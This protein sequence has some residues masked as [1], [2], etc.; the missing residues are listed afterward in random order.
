MQRRRLRI[1]DLSSPSSGFF[2]VSAFLFFA[3][4]LLSGFLLSGCL[5]LPEDDVLQMVSGRDVTLMRFLQV[6]W[7]HFRWI[8]FA[9][10]LSVTTLGLFLLYP[11]VVLRGLLLG[12]SFTALF[13]PGCR[14]AVLLR[15]FLTALLTCSPLLLLAACGV[16]RAARELGRC[17]GG[18]GLFSRPLFLLLLSFL[19][20]LLC[21][22]AELWLL[23]GFASH[24]QPFT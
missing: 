19:L 13:V 11:L 9:G 16:Q 18:E 5:T 15:F 22:F 21:S 20:I 8:A 24:I 2:F 1:L 3:L 14:L 12:F 23:P 6:F 7:S 4:G 10:L 17:S